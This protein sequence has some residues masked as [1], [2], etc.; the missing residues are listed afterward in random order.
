M[1]GKQPAKNSKRFT[2]KRDGDRDIVFSGVEIGEGES[3]DYSAFIYRTDGG[4]FVAALLHSHYSVRNYFGSVAED[5]AGVTAF[6]TREET[7]GTGKN[8]VT[9]SELNEAG[10]LAMQDAA[11]ID[12]SFRDHGFEMVD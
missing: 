6:F 3:G 2:V 8:R 12:D 5:A 1:A 11:R 10:K 7:T 4:K 9:H